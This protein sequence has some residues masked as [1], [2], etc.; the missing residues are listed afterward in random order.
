MNSRKS[1]S[2]AYILAI[3]LGCFGAHLFYI[4]KYKRAGIYLVFCWTYIPLFLGWIDLLFIRKWVIE[5]NN[6]IQKPLIVPLEPFLKMPEKNLEREVLKDSSKL[7][8]EKPNKSRLFYNENEVI[9]DKYAHLMTPQHIIEDLRHLLHSNKKKL[10]T[11]YGITFEISYSS[12]PTSFFQDSIKYA[13]ERGEPAVHQPLMSYWTTFDHLNKKQ[14]EW[15]FYWRNQV[16]Q[17]NYL[18]T[19][20]SYLILFT[21][22]LI[23]YSF[24]QSAAFNIS[25]MVKLLEAYKERNPKVEHYLKSWTH[26]FLIELDEKS[27][28]KEWNSTTVKTNSLYDRLLEKSDSLETVSITLWKQYI[29]GYRETEFFRGNKSKV[30][31]IFKASIP[32]LREA[33]E[34]QGIVFLERWFQEIKGKQINYL[35]GS[36]VIGRNISQ[37]EYFT[38]TIEIRPTQ[39]LYDDITTLFRLAENVTRIVTGEKRQL[40]VNE[41]KLPEGLKERM[42]DMFSKTT[43]SKTRFKKVQDKNSQTEGSKIPQPE[44]EIVPQK[45]FVLDFERVQ[46]LQKAS[47][48]VQLLFEETSVGHSEIASGEQIENENT[49]IPI[50]TADNVTNPDISPIFDKQAEENDMGLVEALTPE[51]LGFLTGFED[52]KRNLIEA[53]QWLKCKGIM[54]GMFISSLNEK[55]HEFLGDNLVE[56]SSQDYELYEEFEYIVERLK[57]GE[58]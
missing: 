32:L 37:R 58:A 56:T 21:Y 10:E 4:G 24:N 6:S 14:K 2:V 50:P 45:V 46:Q 31:K 7:I 34:E 20:L 51:E 49:T 27:L 33:F 47:K 9:L 42:V 26:D 44:T 11:G 57:V 43:A 54:P 38:E 15:Y 12:N 28:A 36:A 19:D 39:E 18:D 35:Y 13:I 16:L 41:E 23:N 5:K 3:F 17:G 30:Y 40:K 8:N 22:E 53:N 55:A 48:E 52:C 29:N 25:M 1:M